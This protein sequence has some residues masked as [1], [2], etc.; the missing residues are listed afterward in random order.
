MAETQVDPREKQLTIEQL[1][2]L[3]ADAEKLIRNNA[4]ISMGIGLVPIP[5]FDMA[6]LLG[7]QLWMIDKL[8]DMYANKRDLVGE[9]FSKEWGKKAVLSLIGALLPQSSLKFTVYSLIKMIPII[10]PTVSTLTLPILCGSTTYAVGRVFNLHFAS[11]RSFLSFNPENYRAYFKEQMNA[12]E[13]IRRETPALNP[14]PM[15]ASI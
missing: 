7:Q 8:G 11:H 6:A 15:A 2:E 9:K 3:N 13:V 10:G 14:D 12:F 5:L 1:A 4:L